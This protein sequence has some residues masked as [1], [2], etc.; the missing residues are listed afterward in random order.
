MTFKIIFFSSMKITKKLRF[1]ACIKLNL[2]KK[3]Y[4]IMYFDGI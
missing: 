2:I 1:F 4:Q 3:D